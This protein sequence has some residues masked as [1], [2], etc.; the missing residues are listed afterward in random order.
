MYRKIVLISFVM[1]LGTLLT[2]FR[3]VSGQV[4]QEQG[5]VMEP[6]NPGVSNPTM[7]RINPGVSNPAEG[8]SLQQPTAR[9][10]HLSCTNSEFAT[11]K[12]CIIGDPSSCVLSH[13][14]CYP[15]RCDTNTKTC[16]MACESI[17]QCCGPAPIA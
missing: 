11:I 12:S 16:A 8:E 14:P 1:I 13:H 10:F 7:E 15:Y 5:Q 4:V 9:T 2:T 3:I 6:I 17:D